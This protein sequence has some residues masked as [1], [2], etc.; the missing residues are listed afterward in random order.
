MSIR[1]T[2]FL[3]LFAIWLT[4]SPN[5]HTANAQLANFAQQGVPPDPGLALLQEEAHD[6]LFLAIVNI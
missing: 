6:L 3:C 1:P 4:V 5:V 2:I